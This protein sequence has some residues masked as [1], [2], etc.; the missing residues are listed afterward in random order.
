MRTESDPAFRGPT[1]ADMRRCKWED[2]AERLY[3]VA[4]FEIVSI[5]GVWSCDSWV[6]AAIASFLF[7]VVLLIFQ[8]FCPYIAG[9]G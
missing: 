7:I 3:F 4:A 8:R 9:G 5:I 2:R 6:G 1:E